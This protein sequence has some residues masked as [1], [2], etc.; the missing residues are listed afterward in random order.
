MKKIILISFLLCISVIAKAETLPTN[1]VVW[2][3]DGSKVVYA[4]A[5]EPKVTFT[6]TDL[7]ISSKGIEVNY[8]IDKMARFTYETNEQTA[9]KNI[10]TGK[11]TLGPGA[12]GSGTFAPF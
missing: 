11:I 12:K 8:A 10:K 3:K 7:V 2:A 1:L 5:D 6:E 4:L 9:I